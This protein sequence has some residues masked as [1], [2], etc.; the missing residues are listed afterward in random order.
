MKIVEK[1][2]GAIAAKDFARGFD[3]AAGELLRGRACEEIRRFAHG[4][5]HPFDRGA[6]LAVFEWSR[7]CGVVDDSARGCPV[8]DKAAE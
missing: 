3:W 4:V 8:V 7:R 6:M 5:D 2:K 1:I